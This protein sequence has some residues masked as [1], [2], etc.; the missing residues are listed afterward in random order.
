[1]DVVVPRSGARVSQTKSGGRVLDFIRPWF[2]V[3]AVKTR[4]SAVFFSVLFTR[5]Y[6][7]PG[8]LKL[9]E[10]VEFFG[11]SAENWHV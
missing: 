5:N 6:G 4:D 3:K 7:L 11:T 10:I 9:S 8:N 1:M 2:Y